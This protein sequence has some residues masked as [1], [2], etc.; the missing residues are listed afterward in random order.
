LTGL[1]KQAG[2]TGKL[3]NKHHI[4]LPHIPHLPPRNLV[5]LFPLKLAILVFAVR[6]T[7]IATFALDAVLALGYL[8][9]RRFT[10]LV[11]CFLNLS[12]SCQLAFY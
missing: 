8:T 7:E 12:V 9:G 1:F 11:I 3:T 10:L 2:G 4:L 5:N 6:Q